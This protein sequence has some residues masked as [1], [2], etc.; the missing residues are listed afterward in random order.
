MAKK[1]SNVTI[2]AK[3]LWPILLSGVLLFTH[4]V[5]PSRVWIVLLWMVGGLTALG[6]YWA[7]QIAMYVTVKREL[8]FGWVQVGDRLEE[9]FTLTNN[10]WLP[11][12]WAEVVDESDL[13]GY[14]VGR[15]ASCEGHNVAHWTTAQECTRRGL[16]TLGPWSLH[17]GDPFGFFSVIFHRDE[18]VGIAV[19]PPVVHLPEITLP[20]G[21]LAGQSRMRYRAIEAVID[22]AQTR[23]YQPKDP[24]RMIHWPSTAHRGSLIVRNPDTEI[25]GDLWIVL[26][27]E[28]RVQVG[29][30]E[31]SSEEYGVILAASLADRTLRQNRAV[32]LMAYGDELALVPPG[33]GRG[34][35][36]RIL[37]ALATASA[38]GTQ[39]LSGVLS[40]VREQLGQGMTVL[41][42][43]PSC[44]P[45]WVD[46]LLPIVRWGIAPTVVLLSPDSFVDPDHPADT[47]RVRAMQELMARAAITTHVIRRGYP[48]RYV[49]P[50]KRR[51]HWEFKVTPMGRAIA[52][53]RP[54]EA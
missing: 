25:S 26:D 54:E 38:E 45:D 52:V 16:F 23:V 33:R 34:H 32:G 53:R 42:I 11:V 30:G 41:V 51:G 44:E 46:A 49:V 31:E 17:T 40:H 2:K 5:S 9:R 29:E 8:R 12:M 19:Y 48:F 1:R 35:M 37:Q 22:A 6:Y 10:S 7:R 28:R 14:K 36:W 21:L 13:P 47:P 43:T 50:P 4:L 18:T 24:L 27:L 20:R 15:V 3:T 39:P